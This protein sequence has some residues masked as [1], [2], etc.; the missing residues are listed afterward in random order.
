MSDMLAEGLA[1]L[2]EQLSANVSQSVTYARGDLSVDVP[3]MLGRKLLKVDDGA[4]GIRI[5]WTDMDFLIPAAS[6][7]LPGDDSPL[8][9]DRGD[10][11][12]VVMPYDVQEFEVEPF[13]NEPC[14]RWSDP[15]ETMY[16]IHT[17]YID[18]E[19]FA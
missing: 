8:T 15:K 5:E 3:A 6:L 7:I 1:F 10:R 2:T 4:G 12:F 17:K 18:S 14:F 11:I 13:G 16:R 19:Q 9:P